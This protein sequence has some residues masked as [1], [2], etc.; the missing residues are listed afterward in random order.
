MQYRKFCLFIG[1]F[2][3]ISVQLSAQIEIDVVY[4][5]EGQK[6]L[7]SESAFIFGSV[8]PTDVD[9]SIND[10]NVKLYSNGA[11]LTTLPVGI[12]E[13]SFV[14]VAMSEDDTTYLVRNVYIPHFLQS[15]P[16]ETMVIDT[17]YIFPKKDWELFP[18]DVF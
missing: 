5:K 13:F 2:I 15:S 16:T 11:F 1:F 4:P 6:I 9:F 14:C 18:G 7:T 3:S 12:G 17:S 8:K 10:K